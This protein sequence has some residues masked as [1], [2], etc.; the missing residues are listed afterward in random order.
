MDW[1]IVAILAL[2][3]AA[4]W[5]TGAWASVRHYFSDAGLKE[6]RDARVRRHARAQRQQR[7]GMDRA[8]PDDAAGI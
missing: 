5:Q 6:R 3:G 1:G 2:A 8:G 7:Q 4:L